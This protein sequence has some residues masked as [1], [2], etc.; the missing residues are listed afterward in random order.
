MAKLLITEALDLLA[1]SILGETLSQKP[2][3]VKLK[4]HNCS[5]N[6]AEL[7]SY[8]ITYFI[9]VEQGRTSNINKW[10]NKHASQQPTTCLKTAVH[11]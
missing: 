4:W 8:H 3:Q 7:L 6:G 1:C 10:K 11:F 5:Q 2:L 9:L